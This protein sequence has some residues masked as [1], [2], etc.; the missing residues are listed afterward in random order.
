[1]LLEVSSLRWWSIQTNIPEKFTFDCGSPLSVFGLWHSPR[2]SD[3]SDVMNKGPIC[4]YFLTTSCN[5]CSITEGEV[6]QTRSTDPASSAQRAGP[7]PI[8]AHPSW[9]IC[10]FIN[11][12]SGA[13]RIALISVINTISSRLI[14]QQTIPDELWLAKTCCGFI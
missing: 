13:V 14:E 6:Q 1:M 5:N 8:Y 3:S 2:Y 4:S 11:Y 12:R 10:V 9:Q 7:S